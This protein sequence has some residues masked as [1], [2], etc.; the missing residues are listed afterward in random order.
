MFENGE[1][2]RHHLVHVVVAISR[3]AADEMHPR[4]GV[5]KLT[6]LLVDCRVLGA[7]NGIIRIAFRAR[8]LVD[9]ARLPV[10]LAGQ[11]F[12]LGHAGEGVVVR[13]IHDRD[14]LPQFLVVRL[15]FEL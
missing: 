8:K 1:R 13:V 4:R 5:D 10:L 11:M 12:E 14:R 6:I 15:V 9:D 2:L 3:E 7:R